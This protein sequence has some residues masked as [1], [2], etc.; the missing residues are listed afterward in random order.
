MAKLQWD[1]Y[2]ACSIRFQQE[3]DQLKAKMLEKMAV[4]GED[5][6]MGVR[7]FLDGLVRTTPEPWPDI[8]R[9]A[10]IGMYTVLCDFDE[11]EP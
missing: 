10:V 8:A 5:W 7:E 6:V 4:G 9:F 2:E 3:F 11:T 1:E